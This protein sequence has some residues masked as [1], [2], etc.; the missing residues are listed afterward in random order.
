LGAAAV[1]V[2]HSGHEGA[3]DLVAEVVRNG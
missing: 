2:E 3:G 1:L